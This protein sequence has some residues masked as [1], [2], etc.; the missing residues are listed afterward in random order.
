MIVW[1]YDSMET[2]LSKL[3]EV[4]KGKEAWLAAAHEVAKSQT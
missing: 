1:H 4:V 3:W 2:S